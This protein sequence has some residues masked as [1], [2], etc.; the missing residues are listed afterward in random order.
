MNLVTGKMTSINK[1]FKLYR[2]AVAIKEYISPNKCFEYY[3]SA[4]GTR[5][6]PAC[7]Q[8]KPAPVFVEM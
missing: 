7:F 2:L 5:V 8:A 3:V 4:R 6:F 1:H